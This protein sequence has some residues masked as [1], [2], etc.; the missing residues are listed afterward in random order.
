MHRSTL[1]RATV[2]VAAMSLM[3]APTAGAAPSPNRVSQELRSDLKVSKIR[4]H[5]QAL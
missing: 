3:L 2:A 4:K 5:Q 1:A